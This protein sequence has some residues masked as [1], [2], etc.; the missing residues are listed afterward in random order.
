[1]NKRQIAKALREAVFTPGKPGPIKIIA[2]VGSTDYYI[3]RSREFLTLSLESP[4]FD[5]CT[6]YLNM[7][8]SLIALAKVNMDNEKANNQ[9]E[10]RNEELI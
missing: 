2:D 10:I 7:A 1:M 4:T 3:N 6:H 5:Q 9:K 8:L